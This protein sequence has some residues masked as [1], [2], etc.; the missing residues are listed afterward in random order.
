MCARARTHACA[1]FDRFGHQERLVVE[2][3]VID[4]RWKTSSEGPEMCL[5]TLVACNKYRYHH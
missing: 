1:Y 3:K 2:W 5:L 4:I